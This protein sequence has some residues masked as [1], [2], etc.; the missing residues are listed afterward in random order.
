MNNNL[1]DDLKV[2][3]CLLVLNAVFALVYFIWR[4]IKKDYQKGTM[5]TL[6]M[7]LA[8]V[9]GPL[10]L[11]ISALL[12]QLYFKHR[13]QILSLEDL[14][15]RKDKIKWIEKEDMVSASNKVPIE[16][17]LLV[18]DVH[19]TR[20]LILN[21]LKD[22]TGDY[23]RSISQAT[24]NEDS[25]VSHYAATAITDIMNTFKQEEKR[26]K[27]QCEADPTDELAI[28]EYW[29]HIKRFLQTG[30]LPRVEQ[31]RYFRILEHLTLQL[32]EEM[33]WLVTGKKYYLLTLL[34]LEAGKMDHAQ[35]WVDK[36][37]SKRRNELHSYKAGLKY[38]YDSNSIEE[39]KA[40]LQELKESSIRLDHDTL[41]LVRFY[42]Q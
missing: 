39:Y 24:S 2:V 35:M 20:R 41:A 13:T 30:V 1:I 21:V 36:A 10:Y 38:Y 9:V 19:S 27:Q 29:T 22:D 23:V 31:A 25:E 11:G 18:S 12:Y 15:F 5:M 40:L 7:L 33:E 4:M 34:S 8:P 28:E 42:G 16:E 14:S 32:E 37:L 17:A 26:L 3:L 6:L